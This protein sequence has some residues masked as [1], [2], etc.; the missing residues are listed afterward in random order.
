MEKLTPEQQDELRL[1]SL[2]E[3]KITS[4]RLFFGVRHGIKNNI[5]YDDTGVF[6]KNRWGRNAIRLYVDNDNKPHFEVFDSLGK[7]V[8]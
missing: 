8:V 1:K 7:S 5:P 3:G 2:Q 4:N 6:I